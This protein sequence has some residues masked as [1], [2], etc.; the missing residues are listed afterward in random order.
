MDNTFLLFERTYPI[1]VHA[2]YGSFESKAEFYIIDGKISE[3]RINLINQ[4]KPL[5]GAQLKDFE[6]FLKV[7]AD[8][9]SKADRLLCFA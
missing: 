5:Q 9:R 4:K 2:N 1:H 6:K 7:Y 8:N 3:I